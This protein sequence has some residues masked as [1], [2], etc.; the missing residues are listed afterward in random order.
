[1][2][3]QDVLDYTR[4]RCG[5]V[6]ND[7]VTDAELTTMVNLALGNLDLVLATQYE[8]YRLTAYLATISGGY[9]ANRIPLPT[10]FLKLRGVDRGSPNQW[11]TIY[12][13]GMQERNRNTNP[14]ALAYV[15]YSYGAV[16]TVRAMDQFIYVEPAMMSGGQY[17][18]WYTPKFQPLVNPTDPL[19]LYMDA[20]G[21][22]E[23]AVSSAG[24]KIYTKLLLNAEPFLAD[25][26]YYEDVV[27]NGASNRMAQGPKCM[28]NVRNLSDTS[29]PFGQGGVGG[30]W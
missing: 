9:N 22:I 29:Y 25:R 23:Y 27:R 21:W 10:D 30:V 3:L 5:I 2:N 14:I 20:E 15:P 11:V 18:V 26:A 28:T 16:V 24:V 19:P 13:F 8:D 4:Q 6:N 12:G 7:V 1:L 17:Q